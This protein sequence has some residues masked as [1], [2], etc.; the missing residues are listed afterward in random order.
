MIILG[1]PERFLDQNRSLLL[2]IYHNAREHIVIVRTLYGILGHGK[3]D[4]SYQPL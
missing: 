3:N 4:A 2:I 1:D